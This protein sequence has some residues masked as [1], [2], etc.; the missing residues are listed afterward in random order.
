MKRYEEP[1]E[2]FLFMMIQ[3]FKGTN[4]KGN[5]EEIL[6]RNLERPQS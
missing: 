3:S 4:R 1:S 6:N 2:R 5:D